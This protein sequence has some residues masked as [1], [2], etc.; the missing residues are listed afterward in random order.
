MAVAIASPDKDFFQLLR[1]GLMLLRPPKKAAAMAA[2]ATG[3]RVNKYALLPYT[4]DNFREEWGGLAPAQFVD[5]LALMG[6]AS[7]NVPGVAGIG[8]KTAMALLNQFGTLE[9]VLAHAADAKPKRAAEA[10]GSYD[11]AAAARLSR[12]LVEIRA[13]LDLPPTQVPLDELRL[14]PPADGGAA[15]AQLFE[16]LEFKTHERRL[17]ALWGSQAAAGHQQLGRS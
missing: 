4:E 13:D 1:P 10:L 12:Q 7:D 15:T 6:D 3:Q 17:R 14:Q 5:V 9:E 11:G 16:A 2:M 8:P